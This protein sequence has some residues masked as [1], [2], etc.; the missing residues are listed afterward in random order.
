MTS[1]AHGS[2]ETAAAYSAVADLYAD[3]ARNYLAR[4][5]LDRALLAAFAELCRSSD[6]GLVADVGCGPGYGTAHLRD[7]GLDVVGFD[8]ST[9]LL[10]IART[11]H[12]E[13]RFE[14]ASMDALPLADGELAGIASWY[15]IIHTA[16]QDVP[17]SLREFA[18][19]LAPGGHLVLAFFESEDDPVSAFD[20]KVITAYRWP[21][22]EVAG[23]ALEA[24]LVEVGRML[25]PPLD[26]ER[27]HRGHLLLRRPGGEAEVDVSPG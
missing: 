25:R 13:L 3:V 4:V 8:V 5:P 6:A 1:V 9:G 17:A 26:G 19:V 12:P 24:G 18:R 21:I 20:H 2:Q 23:L 16:P 22:D 7:L 27:F 11:E 10:D 15:S 14:L